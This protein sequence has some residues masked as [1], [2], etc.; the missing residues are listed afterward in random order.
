LLLWL[1]VVLRSRTTAATAT[2]TA[3]TTA[4]TTG[5][6]GHD[7]DAAGWRNDRDP[8]YQRG[9]DRHTATAIPERR[10]RRDAVRR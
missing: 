5:R 2:T 6:S 10:D 3:A 8:A 7:R 9:H 1:L 4:A